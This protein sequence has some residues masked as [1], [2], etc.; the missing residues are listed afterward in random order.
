[1]SVKKELKKVWC[2]IWS[3]L[4]ND[5][6]DLSTVPEQAETVQA[7]VN[8]AIPF[9]DLSF[10]W[11]GFKGSSAILSTPRI[12]ALSVSFS[13]MSI[14]WDIGLSGWG[15]SDGDYTGALAC[16][17]CKV[18]GQWI[19]GKF[20]WISTSRSTRDFKNIHSGYGGWSVSDFNRAETY[21]FVVVSKDGK[22]RSNVIITG[23]K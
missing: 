10:C 23:N 11:G 20:D 7:D 21:A 14:R 8:D 16:L 22:K 3:W 15:L 12:S 17:F 1:M 5:K 9:A 4:I 13:R 19:G 2:K 6:L 18:D